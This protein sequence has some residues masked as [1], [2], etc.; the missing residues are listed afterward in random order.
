MYGGEH[1][2]D[3]RR[4]PHRR[5]LPY[6]RARH[7]QDTTDPTLGDARHRLLHSPDVVGSEGRPFAG[8]SFLICSSL[9]ASSS[10][11]RDRSAFSAAA[12][13][14]SSTPRS[15]RP[16]AHA[17]ARPRRSTS[18]PGRCSAPAR[19]GASRFTAARLPATSAIAFHPSAAL[20]PRSSGWLQPRGEQ[21]TSP[22]PGRAGAS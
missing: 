15:R 10:F 22:V 19:P 3:D 12:R 1:V 7:G 8:L 11:G 4:A 5:P 21:D 17:C 2:I 16:S 6:R 20:R 9:S 13:K 14:R 18:H